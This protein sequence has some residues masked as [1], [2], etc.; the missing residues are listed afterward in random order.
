MDREEVIRALINVGR[1]LRVVDD[2]EYA[3]IRKRVEYINYEEKEEYL[4][5]R[6]NDR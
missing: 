3:M 6:D 5:T 2:E 4:M 1:P